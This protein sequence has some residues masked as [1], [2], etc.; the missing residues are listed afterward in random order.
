M[1]SVSAAW[2]DGEG[3]EKSDC[4]VGI[5]TAEGLRRNSVAKNWLNCRSLCSEVRPNPGRKQTPPLTFQ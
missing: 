1:T 5:S 4:H 3:D 2:A